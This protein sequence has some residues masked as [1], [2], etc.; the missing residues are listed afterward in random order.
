MTISFGVPAGATIPCHA[1]QSKPGTVAEIGGTS[2]SSVEGLA[3]DVPK[4]I[5][6]PARIF[7]T[8]TVAS[9]NITCIAPLKRSVSAAGVPLYGT[10]WMSR[11][12][13]V[14]SD[15]MKR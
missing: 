5:T 2:G 6:L 4:A 14:L 15:S 11:P 9:A 10:C 1:C 8:A 7:G 3:A 12:Y 13:S